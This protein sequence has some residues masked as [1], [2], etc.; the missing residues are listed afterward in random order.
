VTHDGRRDI[1]DAPD[2]MFRLR[3]HDQYQEENPE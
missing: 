2:P 1:M 3:R